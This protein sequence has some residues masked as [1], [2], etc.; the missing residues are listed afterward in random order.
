M[1]RKR[2]PVTGVHKVRFVKN[3]KDAPPVDHMANYNAAIQD[4]LD[5]LNWPAGD[6]HGASLHL[7]ATIRVVNPGSVIEYCATFI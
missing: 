4:A 2:T 3:V 5:K 1:A 6:H 7:S